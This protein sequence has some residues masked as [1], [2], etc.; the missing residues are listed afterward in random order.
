MMV[1]GSGEPVSLSATT[2]PKTPRTLRGL[3]RKASKCTIQYPEMPARRSEA[4]LKANRRE[5]SPASPWGST[6]PNSR[7]RVSF[8]DEKGFEPAAVATGRSDKEGREAA[9]RRSMQMMG[10]L[11]ALRRVGA[12]S[13]EGETSRPES[14]QSP[15]SA[16]GGEAQPPPAA[17]IKSGGQQ[18]PQEQQQQQQEGE[19]APGGGGQTSPARAGTPAAADEETVNDD[20]L[21][22]TTLGDTEDEEATLRRTE[23]VLARAHEPVQEYGGSRHATAVISARTLAVVRRK[24]HLLQA[25]DARLA[26]FELCQAHREE[27]LRS[28]LSDTAGPPTDFLRLDKFIKA[29]VHPGGGSPLE[30]NKSDFPSFVASFGLPREHKYLKKMVTLGGEETDW[31]AR[32]GLQE[33]QNGTDTAAV[34]RILDLAADILGSAEHPAIR[35][36]RV[37]LGE[38]LALNALKS[39]KLIQE[40]D[41]ARVAGSPKPQ[42][43]SARKSA[44]AI[45]LEIKTAV[46]MGA[47]TKHEALKEA[48]GIATKLEMAE[49]DRLA[50]VVLLFAEDSVKKDQAEA[51][52]C[53]GVPPVGPA[54]NKADTIEREIRLV[55][56]KGVNEFH[57]TLKEALTFCKLLRDKDGERKRLAAREKR[58]AAKAEAEAAARAAAS[59]AEA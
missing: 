41:A 7:K 14:P 11:Y 44:E 33:A 31:W 58:L 40:K 46:A 12:K 56:E 26:A 2:S 19:Q 43:E 9:R 32:A 10:S 36:C 16:S 38:I 34:G 4:L 3:V 6:S 48:K 25:C 24:A 5:V 1:V 20:P 13:A 37:L 59:S 23:A 22:Y 15:P 35:E 50:A 18:P 53:T 51:D 49:K 47:P 8:E 57:P 21:F 30:A 27:T 45:N 28:L 39:A 17:I 42:P 55:V 54:S 52:K 29:H